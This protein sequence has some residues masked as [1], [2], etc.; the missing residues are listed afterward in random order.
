MS[1]PYMGS[2]EAI[3]DDIYAAIH[4]R[5]PDKDAF[6]D[7]FAGGGAMTE[8]FARSGW[9]VISND[10][11]RCISALIKSVYVDGIREKDIKQFIGRDRYDDIVSG[12]SEEWLVGFVRSVYTFGNNGMNYVYSQKAEPEKRAYHQLIF[13]RDPSLFISIYPKLSQS[14]I[15]IANLPNRQIRRQSLLKLGKSVGKV[16]RLESAER[17][18]RINKASSIRRL[19]PSIKVL[20]EDYSEVAIP[21]GAVVYCDPPYAG[22]AGYQVG[23]FDSIKFWDWVRVMSSTNPIYISEYSAPEDFVS[24]LSINKRVTMN[25]NSQTSTERLYVHKS[26]AI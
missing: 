6:V 21:P 13:D 17:I 22:T 9:S 14:A 15:S 5:H 25:V 19:R 3:A 10:K 8:R 12:G 18:D 11:D 2:K 20:N 7:L 1:I 16:F 24:I 26:R 4:K 23:E